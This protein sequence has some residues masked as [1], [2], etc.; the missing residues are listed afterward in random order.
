MAAVEVKNLTFSYDG[1]TNAVED[2]SFSVEPGTYCTI[3]G[4]N[5][6]GKSTV[7]KLITGLLEKKSGEILIEGIPLEKKNLLELRE[8]IGIVFQ[9][10]DNQFIGSTV[11]DDIAFGLENHCVA[12]EEMEVP[13]SI[14]RAYWTYDV[15]SGEC[16]GGHAH[17]QLEQLIIATS[18]SF[19][20]EYKG[21]VKR[22][23]A[24]HLSDR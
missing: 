21:I 18:G 6:S 23:Q 10:P 16:R 22:L 1:E 20:L 13:F 2:V 15:P 17:R 5:G 4:R 11:R 7:A 8:K 9:N 14:A 12:Q 3:V 19:P 24:C